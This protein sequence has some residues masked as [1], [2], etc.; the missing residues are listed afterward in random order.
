LTQLKWAL[1]KIKAIRPL[2]YIEYDK[3]Q[4]KQF[5]QNKYGWLDYGGHHCENLYTM[6]LS[7]YLL[8]KKFGIDKRLVEFSALI[9]SGRITKEE[10]KNMMEEQL[11][12]SHRDLDAILFRLNLSSEEFDDIMREPRKTFKDFKNYHKYF[13]KFKWL[14]WIFVKMKLF[15]KTFYIKYTKNIQF[16]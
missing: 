16:D 3:K 13:V 8:P 12:F 4:V 6:F 5:L 9:R 11:V 14:I 2:Y 1:L 15:P 7:N 10:A